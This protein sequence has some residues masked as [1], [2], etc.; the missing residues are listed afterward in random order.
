MERANEM[1]VGLMVRVVL[2]III[3][4][5][6]LVG[7]LIL[8][9]FYEPSFTTLQKVVTIIVTIIIAFA[10]LG[11]VWVTWAGRRGMMRWWRD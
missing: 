11:I 4:T 7:S 6:F 10:A 5:G 8:V 3:L 9:G 2:S 1:A